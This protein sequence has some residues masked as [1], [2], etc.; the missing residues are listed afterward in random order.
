MTFIRDAAMADLPRIV[1]IYNQA[2]AL[3]S[4]TGDL[5]PLEIDDRRAWLEQRD[6]RLTPV[7]VAE[8]EG[9]VAGYATLDR[10]RGRRAAFDA[11]RELSYYIDERWRR[12]GIASRL[13]E[14]MRARC[15]AIAVDTLIAFVLGHN[16]PSLALL[17]RF[18]FARWGLLP[19]IAAIDGQRRDHVI[20]GLR[21]AQR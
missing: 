1:A 15:D 10:Y 8:I 12:R 6:P 21:L 16:A 2:V 14:A 19:G 7:I 4:A 3:R 18:G 11:V 5:V 13:I 17:E 9:E 20:L